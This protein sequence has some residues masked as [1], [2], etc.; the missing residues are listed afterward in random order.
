LFIAV[1]PPHVATPR[2]PLKTISKNPNPIL[3][4]IS[5]KSL[6]LAYGCDFGNRPSARA[7]QAPLPQGRTQARNVQLRPKIINSFFFASLLMISCRNSFGIDLP[8]LKMRSI[9]LKM[10]VIYLVN[11]R[12]PAAIFCSLA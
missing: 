4:I 11:I 10:A 7:A 8:S 2:N 9:L 6:S 5:L 3:P 1:N 12:R